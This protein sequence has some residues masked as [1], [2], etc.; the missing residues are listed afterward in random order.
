MIEVPTSLRR[1]LPGE[2][3]PFAKLTRAQVEEI[4]GLRAQGMTYR[5]IASRFGVHLSLAWRICARRGWVSEA[6]GTLRRATEDDL[7]RV[8]EL[9][10]Q[11]MGRRRIAQE[12]K[13][14]ESSIAALL[15]ALKGARTADKARCNAA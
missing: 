3:N 14:N 4:K 10:A 6:V 12:L 8:A 7:A 15:A 2:A 11:G 13:C 1:G 5:A 9:H